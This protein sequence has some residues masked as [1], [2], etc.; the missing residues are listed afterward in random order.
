MAKTHFPVRFA[1]VVMINCWPKTSVKCHKGRNKA[2]KILNT[3]ISTNPY[4]IA[5]FP[6]GFHYTLQKHDN[7][8]C[9]EF[10]IR[11]AT[12]QSA[13][14]DRFFLDTTALVVNLLLLHHRLLFMFNCSFIDV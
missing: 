4:K 8:Y 2:I 6:V 12:L 1:S 10:S 9:R 7:P 14:L 3:K 5:I 11:E 13:L